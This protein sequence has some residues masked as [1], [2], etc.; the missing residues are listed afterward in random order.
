MPNA[1][2]P[3]SLRRVTTA[4]AIGN[5]VE[6]FDFAIYGFLATIIAKQFFPHE[7]QQASLLETFAVFA[8]AFALRP[9]GGVFFGRL[10]DRIGRKQTLSLTILLMA[11]ATCL[12]GLLPTYAQVGLWAPLAL[13]LARC[14]QGFSA[15]GEYAGACAFVME[16]A[17]P[18][19]RARVGSFLPVSTFTAF[20]CAAS[21]AYLLDVALGSAAMA[22]WGWRIPFIAAAPMGLIGIYLRTRLGESPEFAKASA[23]TKTDGD[24]PHAPLRAAMQ[25]H[26]GVV[27]S[28]AAFIAVTALSFYTFTTYF[29]TYLQVAGGMSRAQALLVTV[30]ALCL[31]VCMCPLA[32]RYADHV[33]RRRSMQTV[34]ALV[35]LTVYPSFKLAQEGNLGL[36]I[37]G[38][39]LQAMGAVLSGVVTVALLSESFPTR[40]RYTA[41][42][43]AYNVAYTLFGGTAPFVATYLIGATGN[44]MAPAFYLMA[45]AVLALLGGMRLPETSHVRLADVR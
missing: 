22:D 19:R 7:D 6:W 2:P 27:A 5:F 10:G 38:V 8:V 14:L 39:S 31:A 18:G 29:A 30:V 15:G 21:V 33:G 16:H 23:N 42:A 34:C 12:V 11:G 41:S 36:A 3:S 43:M 25:S 44:R 45:V 32:G 17:A 9:I 1:H 28:L 20:A 24:K 13:V 4:A 40:I 37:L 26:G 35:L